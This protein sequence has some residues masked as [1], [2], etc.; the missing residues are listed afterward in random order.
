[1]LWIRQSIEIYG[2]I[3]MKN[4]V[5]DTIG[6]VGMLLSPRALELLNGIEKIQPRNLSSTFNGDPCITIISCYSLTNVSYKMDAITFHN[7]LSSLVVFI[8]CDDIN[9]HINKDENNKFCLCNSPN[10][11]D[12]HLAENRLIWLKIK[13]QKNEGKTMDLPRPRKLRRSARLYINK[14][15]INSDVICEAY[16]SFEK[17]FRSLN[18][19]CK[20]SL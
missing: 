5:K 9:A 6:D 17:A 12:G 3:F 2:G 20:D 13:F 1:M 11:N 15:R 19:L 16:S 8:I 14:K 4:S 7:K 10:K 18:R